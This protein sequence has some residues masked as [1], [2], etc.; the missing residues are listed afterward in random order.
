MAKIVEFKKSKEIFKP[1]EQ[2]LNDVADY[3]SIEIEDAL[4]SRDALEVSWR[5]NLRQYEG[6]PN[7]EVQDFP[8]EN[9][10]NVEVTLGAIAADS[11]YAQAVD[12]IYSVRPLVT[13]RGVP[14]KKGDLE[15]SA[16]VKALQR[17][18][19]W[20]ADNESDIR[21]TGDEAI[22]DDVQ[23]GTG[24]FYVPWVKKIKK[25]RISKVVSQG[26]RI[27][28]V[29]PEDCLVPGGT[30]S[31]LDELPWIGLRF[32]KTK[33]EVIQ[34]AKANNWDLGEGNE[35]ITPSGSKDWVRNRREALG[36]HVEGVQRKG[37]LY[38]IF[39][40]YLHFDVDED[41]I[42]EDLYAVFDRTSRKVLK[43]SYNPY[44]HRP[45]EAFVYQRR[46]HMFYGI[47]VLQMMGPYQEELT[48]LHNYQILNVLLA[49]CRLWLGREG[50][51]P[52][53]MKLYPNK[54]I[55]T[56]EP[57]EDLI[58][59][60]MADTYPSL[61]MVQQQIVQLAER[62]VG[63]NELTPRPSATLGTRTPGITAMS[64]LQQV[65]K[66]FTPA[67]AGIRDGFSAALKQCLYRYQEQLLIGNHEVA[68]HIR[69]VL[70]VED[71]SRVIDILKQESF[72]EH[73]SMELTASD[74]SVN[75]EAD[76][77]NALM[78]SNLLAQYYEKT[79]NLVT[80]AV[81]PQTPPAVQAVAK[82]VAESASEMIDRTIRT[83]DQIRDPALF[84]IDVNDEIDEAAASAPQNA[85][86]QLIGSMGAGEQAGPVPVGPPIEEGTV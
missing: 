65:N 50:R 34:D 56:M 83:F 47:G 29:A 40:V 75:K 9:A 73:L 18:V 57:K 13:V 64:M 37:E 54:V 48:D 78:L 28:T 43:L 39:D 82:K 67:F 70:G 27:R 24:C 10:P 46:A 59:L 49:N 17:W 76:R 26:P 51:I 80:I 53:N 32:W 31:E 44:D 61:G 11:I 69:R 6:Q 81:N 36:K 12:L 42:N 14:K 15:T 63:V 4:S 58:P 7:R 1:T 68:A 3:L 55:T 72:D 86:Q 62:R 30:N 16:N 77:Q 60:Q 41:G 23:L 35:K 25:T 74:A 84:V 8:I 79:L 20:M 52:S 19:N 38:E 21:T 45:V 66:R 71:G 5:E 22:L 85:L 2:Q 33:N